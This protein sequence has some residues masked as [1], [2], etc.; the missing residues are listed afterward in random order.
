MRSDQILRYINRFTH[1]FFI[2]SIL[3]AVGRQDLQPSNTNTLH[4][5]SFYGDEVLLSQLHHLSAL[6]LTAGISL[7]AVQVSLLSLF[8]RLLWS[9]A[10]PVSERDPRSDREVLRERVSGGGDREAAR[11]EPQAEGQL[12]TL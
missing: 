7:N 9:S 12:L 8:V 2:L 3:A 10:A 1:A 6:R 4:D 5:G 11:G